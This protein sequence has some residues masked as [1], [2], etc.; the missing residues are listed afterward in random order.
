MAKNIYFGFCASGI[1]FA[2]FFANKELVACNSIEIMQK[3]N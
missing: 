3:K 1:N 2:A